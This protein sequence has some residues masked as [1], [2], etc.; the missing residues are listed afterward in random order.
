MLLYEMVTSGSVPYAC[1][2]NMQ[3]RSKVAEGYRLMQPHNCPDELYSLML[4]CWLPRVTE[5]PSFDDVLR[6]HLQPLEVKVRDGQLN[7][8]S[9]TTSDDGG[10]GK[11]YHSALNCL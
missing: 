3:V 7:R 5:R 4:R 11:R 10:E 8:Q 6:K 9:S 2:C 1:F